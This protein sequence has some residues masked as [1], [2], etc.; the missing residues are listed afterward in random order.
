MFS[1]KTV[2]ADG[3]ISL[4]KNGSPQGIGRLLQNGDDH[5]AAQSMELSI[6]RQ[7]AFEFLYPTNTF[8]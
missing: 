7:A 1:T 2:F 4:A 8:R 6:E 3:W 5:F